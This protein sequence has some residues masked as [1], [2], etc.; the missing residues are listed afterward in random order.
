MKVVYIA[1]PFRASNSWDME[2]N[3]RRAEEIALRV[4]RLGLAVICPHANTR[5]FQG[6]AEDRVWLDGDLELL[7]RSDAVLLVSGWEN[8]SGTRQEVAAAKALGIPVFHSV[9]ELCGAYGMHE[10]FERAEGI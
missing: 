9:T 3:I 5:F 4:W 1:G 8:S 7:R 6:A 2:Q 10:V